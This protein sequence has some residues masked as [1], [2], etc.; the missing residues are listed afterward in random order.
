MAK[1]ITLVD[2]RGRFIHVGTHASPF[3]DFLQDRFQKL[4][5]MDDTVVV[6]VLNNFDKL[7]HDGAVFR[8]AL[9]DWLWEC[10]YTTKVMCQL[11]DESAR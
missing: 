2:N 6:G 1:N 11:T 9:L 4:V 10:H 5:Q 8:G 3:T 7:N